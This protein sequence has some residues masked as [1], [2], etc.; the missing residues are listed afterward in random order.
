MLN[1]LSHPGA[2][3]TLIILTVVKLRE[4]RNNNDLRK[5]R[6]RYNY[7]LSGGGKIDVI[8]LKV[9]WQFQLKHIRAGHLG[10]SV[11]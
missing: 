6:E 9:I 8:C 10:G 4:N 7:K 2:S 1:Q 3:K 5:L 11:S